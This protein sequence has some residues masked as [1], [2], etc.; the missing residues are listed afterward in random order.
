MKGKERQT[1]RQKTAE[2]IGRNR[3]DMEGTEGSARSTAGKNIRNKDGEND[4]WEINNPS[5]WTDSN[6]DQ[7]AA[8]VRHKPSADYATAIWNTYAGL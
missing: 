3:Q 4:K 5:T 7:V 6:I 2:F 1:E 8:A